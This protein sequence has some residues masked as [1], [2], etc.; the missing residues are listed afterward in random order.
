MKEKIKTRKGFIQIPLLI[1]IIVSVAVASGLGYGTVE[2]HKTSKIVKESEQLTKEEKYNEAI[3]KLEVAQNKF[4][5]K[6]ILKQK[7]NI[8]L[9]EN[10]KLIADK[11]KYD[12][13]IKEFNN[14][15]FQKSI[16]LLSKLPENSS[17]YQKAQ[18]KIEEAKRKM[19][20]AKL[21]KEQITREEAEA[22]ARQEEAKAR[23]EE[24]EK[25]LKEQQLISKEAEE[26]MMNADNDGD[27]LTYKEELQKGTSDWNKDSDFDGIP[28]NL[29][30]H[31][32]GGGRYQ[33]QTFAWS[34]GG[35]NWTW[36]AN[37]HEDWYEYYKAKKRLPNLSVE[38]VTYND[39]FIRDI[40]EKISEAAEKNNLNKTY[41]AIAFVQSL[42][43]VK[44]IYTGYDDYPKYP[45]ETFFEKNGDCEDTSYLLASIIRAMNIGCALISL[46]GHAAVGI[47]SDCKMP[48]TYYRVGDRCYYYAET[49]GEGWS[50]GE[51][52]DAF[53]YTP[54]TLIEIP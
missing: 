53:K 18:T 3:K 45:V 4:L 10:K 14:N 47:W 42:D 24:A 41:L 11:T 39:P 52:P 35:Y 8:K 46:P 51:I 20:E 13:G 48:G 44:D 32:A 9:E 38:Y 17:Y 12:E 6:T 15:N 31:P 34:Y 21:S 2:Y 29:D 7:I 25:E 40:A 22:K 37:I 54:A 5:G 49:T 1:A 26:R 43:Y 28:D 27:G 50:L 30:L 36:T 23:Q 16:D 33:A 19:I